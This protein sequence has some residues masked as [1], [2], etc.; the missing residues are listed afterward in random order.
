V[1]TLSEP[2][3]DAG[4]NQRAVIALSAILVLLFLLLCAVSYFFM[5]F[6]VPA[7]LPEQT[8]T[9]GGM[10]WVRSIYGFGPSAT[11]QLLGPT[12]VAV[13]PDGTIYA[14]DP[15]RAR[16]LAFNP[17]GTFKGLIFTGVG[18]KGKGQVGRPA[19]VAVDADGLVYVSDY[20]NGKIIV[21]DDRFTF[22]REWQAPQ[23]VGI[24]VIGD[25]VYVRAA[26]EV[27]R[28][29]L[30]G[31]EKSR[32]IKR[33]RGA[34]AVLEPAGGITADAKR[35]YAAD[36]LNQSIKAFDTDG[37]LLWAAPQR[38][39]AESASVATTE[40]LT[41]DRDVRVDLPQDVVL[42]RAGRVVVVDA[43]SFSIL[44]I[45]A[46]SGEILESYG[47]Q[48]AADGEFIYPSSIAYDAARDWFVV[49]D[50]AN[51]RVQIVRIAGS[52][53]G[54]GQTAAR[55]LSSP[56]RVCAVPLVVLVAALALL[57]ATRRRRAESQLVEVRD[58]P[59]AGDFDAE[60]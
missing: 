14:T 3:R 37:A 32:I 2:N 17:D 58:E 47:Q 41:E 11:D 7:G 55:A 5:R 19:D 22:V 35:I 31:A 43:F 1:S 30:D 56:F 49:A 54:V 46:A 23:S 52:G 20:A 27:V 39:A 9:S 18:G 36:A 12:A 50:T 45:D 34:G 60:A 15:Q 53:G 51:N 26:G 42:D 16:V 38:S 24:D 48:G 21:F 59:D 10:T 57:F 6:L 29:A 8:G 33:G 40:A 28:Y 13:A 44:A 4:T 25:T